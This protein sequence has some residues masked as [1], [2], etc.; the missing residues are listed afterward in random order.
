MGTLNNIEKAEQ[1]RQNSIAFINATQQL[2]TSE[3]LDHISIRKIAEKAG[4]HN[5]TLYLYFTDLNQLVMLASMKYFNEYSHSLEIQSQKKLSPIENFLSIW[6]LFLNTVFKEPYIFNNFFYGKYS[7]NLKEIMTTYY[8]LFPEE[9][10]HFSKEIEEMYFGKN[11]I[12]RSLNILKPLIG[13]TDSLTEENVTTANELIVSY[14]KYKLD[15]KCADPSL[16]STQ[17]K[18][19]I[20]Q[21]ISFI[22]TK[23]V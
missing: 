17:L 15:L 9:R 1:K 11:I 13:I 16:D 23:S 14:C 7:D 20:M 2:I 3:G 10:Y 22:L 6:S 12:E 4:F 18:K 8:E 5:S 21:A 19:E